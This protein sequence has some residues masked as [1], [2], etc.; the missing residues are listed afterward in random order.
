[1]KS[2]N[3]L[4]DFTDRARVTHAQVDWNWNTECCQG[5]SIAMLETHSC[6]IKARSRSQFVSNKIF[7]RQGLC[8][9]VWGFAAQ[10][11]RKCLRHWVKQCWWQAGWSC[12]FAAQKFPLH[13]SALPGFGQGS[14]TATRVSLARTLRAHK[15]PE[16]SHFKLWVIKPSFAQANLVSSYWGSVRRSFLATTL[17]ISFKIYK[18]WISNNFCVKAINNNN[19]KHIVLPVICL[20]LYALGWGYGNASK[21]ED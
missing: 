19:N 9:Q 13:R 12:S 7:L 21:A 5:I 11:G 1:M 16:R 15:A 8:C 6:Y 4:N 2:Q 20:V 10:P 3:S 18:L 17:F 14:Y